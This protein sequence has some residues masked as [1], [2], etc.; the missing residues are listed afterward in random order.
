MYLMFRYHDMMP[1][2]FFK[3]KY[4]EKHVIRAFMYQEIDERIE[5]IKS[6]GKGM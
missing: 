4:G 5:E 6:F 2:D 1:A 3:L